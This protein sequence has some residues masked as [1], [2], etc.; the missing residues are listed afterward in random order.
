M[1]KG[2]RWE[3]NQ[4]TAV[5]SSSWT[6]PFARM[7]SLIPSGLPQDTDL[8]LCYDMGHKRRGRAVIFN[9]INFEDPE[10]ERRDGTNRDRDSLKETLRKMRFQD[11]DITVYEDCGVSEIKKVIKD[12]SNDDH[13]DADC[14]LVA[15]FTHGGDRYLCA[16]DGTCYL[17]EIF[18]KPF[19]EADPT[20]VS[21]LA[22]KPKIFIIQAC[23]GEKV[24]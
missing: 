22:G 8:E 5:V 6:N 12:L 20:R 17:Q 1:I 14:L 9:H 10:L 13:T 16:S 3:F 7:D 18:W 19:L 24:G 21:S 15:V 11:E 23:R 2:T 4:A